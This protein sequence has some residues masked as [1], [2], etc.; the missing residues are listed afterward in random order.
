MNSK[1][2]KGKA[3]YFT[4]ASPVKESPKKK[5]SMI[6][7]SSS[8]PSLRH[9]SSVPGTDL[10]EAPSFNGR[11]GSPRYTTLKLLPKEQQTGYNPFSIYLD[12]QGEVDFDEMRAVSSS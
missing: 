6:E 11:S 2:S 4:Q 5:L 10:F 12:T 3:K 9:V 1:S 7:Q 8:I